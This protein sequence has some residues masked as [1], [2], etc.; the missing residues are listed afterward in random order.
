MYSKKAA[1]GKKPEASG[2]IP[3]SFRDPSG[4]LF[5][6]DRKIFRQVN[7]S[8][9]DNYNHLIN[10]GLYNALVDENLLIPHREA[11]FSGNKPD[12]AY[13]VIEP[14]II[15]FISYPYEW[16]FSQLKD[17][18]LTTLAIQK[19]S[20]D[21]GMSLKDCSAYNIQFLKGRPV[22]ID[23]L[24]FEKYREG[25][26]WV[27][28]RQFCQHFLAPLALMVY[29]D[30]RLNQLFRVNIDGL[31]LDLTSS[32]LP[33]RTRFIF[34]LLSHIHLHARSQKHFANKTINVNRHKISRLSFL[35]L[36]DSLEKAVCAVKTRIRRICQ[37]SSSSIKV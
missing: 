26:P 15:R 12:E 5:Y 17:A 32:L 11:G 25:Y 37:K 35:G 19:K 28:Y 34:S 18:A 36:I 4:F 20:L 27:A 9:K 21:Y 22:F 29:R 33:F 31:P 6:R 1:T 24:S 3:G 23:T 16:C 2:N 8:Y 13:K 10:S 30:I 14:E 7:L